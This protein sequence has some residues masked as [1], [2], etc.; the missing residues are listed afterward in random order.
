LA[1]L[2]ML[3]MATYALGATKGGE[4]VPIIRQADLDQTPCFVYL[5]PHDAE[6]P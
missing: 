3:V 6:C 1:R 4:M 5:L 2:R